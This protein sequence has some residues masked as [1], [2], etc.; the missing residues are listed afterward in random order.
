MR[1]VEDLVL[2][3]ENKFFPAP[4]PKNEQ[5][6]LE[7]VRRTGVM[8]VDNKDLFIVYNELAKQISNMPVSYTG[9]IDERRQYMLCHVGLPE[10]MPA[11]AIRENT[12]C[13]YAL[14][15]T[16]PLIIENCKEDYRFKYHPIVT[17]PP[18][19]HFYGGFPIVNQAGLVLGTLCVTDTD[20]KAKL[21][22]GQIKLLEKLTSRLAH[23]LD[24]QVAQ[25]EI[26]ASKTK[27]LLLE[28]QRKFP[29]FNIADLIAFLSLIQ[30]DQL[31]SKEKILLKNNKL[32]NNDNQMTDV[33]RI[34]QKQI[35]L[36]SGIFRR[37]VTSNDNIQENLDNM[38][39][40]LDMN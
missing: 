27:S 20:S 25:R 19:V 38:L 9:L 39:N 5:R 33:A 34:F 32:I 16:E 17:G 18:F 4:V 24:T 11:D 36:D 35:G 6:R 22:Q 3:E 14:N 7:A 31:G 21:D 28:T 10:D 40:E 29:H 26:T 13:Q 12:F 1:N 30:G 2:S 37:M 23:Q 8:D 15:S